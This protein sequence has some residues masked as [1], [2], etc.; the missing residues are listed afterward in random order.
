[1][2]MLSRRSVSCS[3]G[4][5]EKSVVIRESMLLWSS[6]DRSSAAGNPGPTNGLILR[7]V[8]RYGRKVAFSSH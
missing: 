3:G 7:L 4:V 6:F 2:L 1:M 8:R 5:P